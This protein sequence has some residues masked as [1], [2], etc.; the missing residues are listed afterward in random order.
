MKLH[1]WED[2]RDEL[3]TKEEQARTNR[4]VAKEVLRLNLRAVRQLVGKRQVDVAK[5]AKMSQS[6]VSRIESA[7]SLMVETTRR[8]VEALGGTLELT[9]RFGDKSVRLHL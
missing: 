4:K 8:Y 9:A 6:E 3:F 2:I 1:K 5:K 7:R